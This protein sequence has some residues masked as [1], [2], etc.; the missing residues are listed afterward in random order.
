[1]SNLSYLNPSPVW[2][3]FEE[4]CKIPR[5]SGN[6]SGIRKFLLDFALKNN[7]ESRSDAAGNILIIRP[8]SPGLEN[9]KTVVLQS[10]LDMVGEKISDIP[11]NWTT[12]PVI[13]FIK[14]GWVMAKGT[15]LGADD[16]IGIAAQMAILTDQH[17]QTGE[18][19]C[20]FTVDEESGMTGAF[21]LEPGFFNGRILL[22]LDSE[23]E[24]VLYIGCAGGS[25]TVGT[26]KYRTHKS[27]SDSSAME[28]EIKGLHGGHSGDEIHKGYGNSIKIMSRLLIEISGKSEISLASLNGGNL[29]NAIPREASSTIV[30]DKNHFEPVKQLINEFF[31]SI[32]RETGDIEKEMII[33]SREV[34]LPAYVM[35]KD[36]EAKLIDAL[37]CCPH[38][39]IEWS[40]D[41]EDLVETSTNL[42][43]VKFTGSNTIVITTTQRSSVGSSK[44]VA[45]RMVETCLKSAGAEVVHSEGYPG[46]KP[47][48]ASGILAITRKS[49]AGLFGKEPVVRAIHAGLECGLIKE[50]IKGIDMISFGP[51]I[52]GAHTPSEMIEISTVEMFWRLLIEVIK[53]IPVTGE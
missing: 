1:M 20:L 45:A 14:E 9:R 39:V 47:D 53:N 36:D 19:E 44:Y 18:I 26:I 41:M 10:H 5:T 34:S 31:S 29:R 15:T 12:D 21:A 35:D 50:K 27:E 17:L 11:H 25:D 3:W 43:S 48:L 42:A 32:T 52:K 37:I 7:L 46:W 40:K 51:T 2:I 49:Y 13:P 16:G 30:V 24:G 23:D 8:A 22:N 38:G 4:L 33:S 28:I 6:E